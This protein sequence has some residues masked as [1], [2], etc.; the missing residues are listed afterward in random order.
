MYQLTLW[1]LSP[2]IRLLLVSLFFPLRFPFYLWLLP[3][4]LGFLITHRFYRMCQMGFFLA[5]P[6]GTHKTCQSV[7][8]DLLQLRKIYLLHNY[9]YFHLYVSSGWVLLL[10][11]LFLSLYTFALMFEIFFST[12]FSSYFFL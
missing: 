8:S 4:S 6:S 12:G 11:F 5:L 10:S 1:V 7:D 2:S 9:C 3:P